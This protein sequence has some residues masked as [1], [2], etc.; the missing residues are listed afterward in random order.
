MTF[1]VTII[2]PNN[3]RSGYLQSEFVASGL[4]YTTNKFSFD[5]SL[6]TNRNQISLGFQL[7][8]KTTRDLT[9]LARIKTLSLSNDPYFEMRVGGRHFDQWATDVAMNKGPWRLVSEERCVAEVFEL[10]DERFEDVFRQAKY[11]MEYA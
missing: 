5:P 6:D 8:N 7:R 2:L 10:E 9:T 4:A 3:L 1:D 11:L